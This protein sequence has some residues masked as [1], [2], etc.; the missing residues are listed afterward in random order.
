MQNAYDSSRARRPLE[1][2][3]GP[4]DL[5]RGTRDE[6][7]ADTARTAHPDSVEAALTTIALLLVI[8]LALVLV[9]RYWPHS[10]RRTGYHISRPDETPGEEPPVPEDDDARWRWGDR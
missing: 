4:L 1:G 10:S 7:R 9:A 2:P 8:V 6:V 5:R 3:D